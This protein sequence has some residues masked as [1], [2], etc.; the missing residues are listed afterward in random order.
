VYFSLKYYQN[1]ED[2]LA[3]ILQQ[4]FKAVKFSILEK[5]QILQDFYIS[6]PIK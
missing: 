6:K 1:L 5:Y 2:A 4:I 3:H